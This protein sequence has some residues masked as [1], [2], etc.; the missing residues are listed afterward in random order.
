[1]RFDHYLTK[2]EK[3]SEYRKFLKGNRN[4]YLCSG[5]FVMDL[6]TEKNMHQIDYYLPSKKKFANFV[7]DEG[8]KVQLS[9]GAK[10]KKPEKLK[11]EI[12]TDIEALKGIVEDEMKN[13]TVTAELKKIIAVL[14]T[15]EGK[16]VWN[17]NCLTGDMGLIKVHIDD[18]SGN[19]LKFE[20]ASLFDFIKK[21]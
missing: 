21:I 4:A 6:D 17:L 2:V 19:I 9:E 13:R 11:N 3:S 20:K 7:L 14:Q 16:N 5:F 15:I 10:D 12:K 18:D 8:V 1:M